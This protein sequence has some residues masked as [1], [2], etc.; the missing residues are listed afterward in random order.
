MDK[1]I[2][3]KAFCLFI[4][5]KNEVLSCE[6]YLVSVAGSYLSVIGA[7]ST[8]PQTPG[9]DSGVIAVNERGKFMWIHFQIGKPV[10]ACLWQG[11]F[12]SVPVNKN[13]SS[14]S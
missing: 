6:G 3:S 1:Y 2:F 5:L 12:N 9:L 7:E 10:D 11:G 13:S 14:T 4:C 8:V